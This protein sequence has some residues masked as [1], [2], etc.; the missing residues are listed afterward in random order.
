MSSGSGCVREAQADKCA[1]LILKLLD[2]RRHF[3]SRLATARNL[4]PRNPIAPKKRDFRKLTYRGF[5]T[6]REPDFSG[7]IPL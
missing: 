3:R 5:S 4:A 7:A 6:F 1:P 2:R